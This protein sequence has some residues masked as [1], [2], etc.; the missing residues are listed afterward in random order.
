MSGLL[1]KLTW[2]FVNLDA[3]QAV[4]PLIVPFAIAFGLYQSHYPWVLLRALHHRAFGDG[5]VPYTAKDAPSLGMTMPTL[6]RNR[7]DLN[8]LKTGLASVAACGYRG[9][10]TVIAVID[11]LDVAPDLVSELR[12]FVAGL[13]L[14]ENLRMSVTG[15]PQRLGKAMAGDLGVQQFAAM[16]RA[17]LIPERPAIYFNMDA[18]CELGPHALDRMIRAL[19][20]PS[21]I[22]GKPAMIVTSHVSIRESEYLRSFRDLFTL[23]GLIA[24]TVAREYLVAIGLGRTNTLRVLPQ[25]GASGALYCTWMEIGRAHV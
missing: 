4:A 13:A 22:T 25:N 17:G 10:L 24:V 2:F 11:G 16:A 7:D 20:R 6:L 14:P 8:G 15:S 3:H 21:R 1:D 23:R 18:D 19:T 12:A 9:R 5:F